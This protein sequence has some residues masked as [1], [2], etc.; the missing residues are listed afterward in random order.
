MIRY[1]RYGTLIGSVL[2]GA[3]CGEST[4]PDE[5]NVVPTPDYVTP[6]QV[7]TLTSRVSGLA[8]D[9]EA[10]FMNLAHC[11]MECPF[12]PILSENNPLYL[13]SS[14]SGASVSIFDP[15]PLFIPNFPAVSVSPEQ[16]DFIG[17]WVLPTVP[18][19]EGIP[20]FILSSGTGSLPPANAP[21]P[22]LATIPP[23]E[24]VKTL[25]IRPIVASASTCVTMS[26]GQIAKNGVMEAAAKF[27]SAT[28]EPTTVE[29]LINP[30]KFYG[31]N[32]FWLYHAGNPGLKA[33]ADRTTIEASEGQLLHIDWAP[34]G[35]LPPFLNQSARGFY[36]TNTPT[37]PLGV[38][39]S[40]LRNK[41]EN[42]P[43]ERTIQYKFVDTVTDA[44]AKR[45]WVFPS[46]EGH[47]TPGQVSY[48]GLQFFYPT[49]PEAPP[50]A[51]PPPS[52]CLP[53]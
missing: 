18:S 23:S 4:A 22:P 38:I 5:S 7:P 30:D 51:P 46:V 36:V 42:R 1:I 20:Y 12:P 14:V 6:D 43:K 52:L 28:E 35:V 16:S 34:P 24:Y 31:F 50:G 49:P 45:P 19:R 2:L 11:G 53:Q 48:A 27:L 32:I 9:P 17:Q 21:F 3:A 10:F 47:F 37:S 33:P 39:V 13:R 25:T 8:W 26:A 41:G 44:A 29:D 40:Y 15:A